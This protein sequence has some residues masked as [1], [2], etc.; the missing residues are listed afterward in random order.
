MF[1]YGIEWMNY[2]RGFTPRAR[3]YIDSM[4]LEGVLRQSFAGFWFSVAMESGTPHWLMDSADTQINLRTVST[5]INYGAV[6]SCPQARSRRYASSGS[7]WQTW[8]DK[9]G[10]IHWAGSGYAG[11]GLP[12]ETERHWGNF[13]E[14]SLAVFRGEFFG[15]G[16]LKWSNQALAKNRCTLQWGNWGQFRKEVIYRSVDRIERK[17]GCGVHWY[18]QQWGLKGK[19]RERERENPGTQ[20]KLSL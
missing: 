10:S 20:R 14:D 15:I 5:V 11:D 17:Q 18:Y 16:C 1:Y 13:S 2:F 6:P 8:S 3:R 19:E 12:L 7:Q 4:Q 9:I